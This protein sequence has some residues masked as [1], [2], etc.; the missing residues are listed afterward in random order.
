M[1]NNKKYIGVFFIIALLLI[2]LAGCGTKT[3]DTSATTSAS[4]TINDPNF[5]YSD[6]IDQNGFWTGIKALD[7]VTMFQYKGLSIPSDSH[8]VTDADV[9]SQIDSLLTSYATTKQVTD[10]AVTA[11]DTVN[12]DYVGSVDGTPFDGGS[13]NGSGTDVTISTTNYIPGFLDQLVG[14]MPG[15]TFNINV[16]FPT[17]YSEATLQ[18][19]A[20]IF[21]TTINYIVETIP[22]ELT[23]DFVAT[24]MEAAVGWKT[25]DDLKAGI[26]E[27]LQQRAIEQYIGQYF[28][29]QVTVKSVPDQLVTYEEKAMVKYYRDTATSY[30]TDL[31]TFLSSYAGVSSVDDLI[32]KNLADYKNQAT[33]YLVAQAVAEDAG[34]SVSDD[35]LANYMQSVIG[36]SDYSQYESQFGIPYMKQAALVQKVL[37]LVSANAVLA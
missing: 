8:T 5:S 3:A 29:T 22:A 11:D 16:T 24:N 30:G 34:L 28:T 10:R 6:G 36:T 19:K 2:S 17:D 26:K 37:D 23:D 31:D 14:H 13:T 1:K 4:D 27:E 32:Q 15:E 21:V 20:A 9:Q 35:D 12:I 25:V 33:Y 7:Y 18:G